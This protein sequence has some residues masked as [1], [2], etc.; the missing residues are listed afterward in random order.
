MS[1]KSEP[2]DDKEIQKAKPA[3]KPGKAGK[4]E[5]M[6]SAQAKDYYNKG[7]EF[8]RQGN[9]NEAVTYYQKAIFLDQD[10]APAFNQLGILYEAGGM[11]QK[12]E[13]MY[14]KTVRIDE[15][16]LAAYSNLALLNEEKGDRLKAMQYWQKRIDLG[17]E[18]DP[19]TIE[20]VKRLE[21]LK[22]KKK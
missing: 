11:A 13:E 1:G 18:F 10:F 8:Q 22:T 2:Q 3:A 21:K 17:D 19:W 15:G 4:E 7:L 12:A 6:F 20:A 9:F 14:L 5:G 16:Y